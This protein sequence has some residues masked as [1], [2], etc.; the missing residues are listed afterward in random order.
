MQLTMSSKGKKSKFIDFSKQH[1]YSTNEH[2][3]RLT[4]QYFN[5]M[6]AIIIK[7]LLLFSLQL[8]PSYFFVVFFLFCSTLSVGFY[9]I[10]FAILSIV[11]HIFRLCV[12]VCVF[13]FVLLVLQLFAGSYLCPRWLFHQL[14][15]FWKGVGGGGRWTVKEDYSKLL[16]S[17]PGTC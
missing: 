12:S 15:L 5:A 2:K 1:H 9:L 7:G 14:S 13:F 8:F 3:T 4:E 17:A 16:K 10:F 6:W 11:P